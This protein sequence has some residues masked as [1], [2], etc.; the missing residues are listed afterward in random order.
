MK[1]AT[2]CT[3][4][5]IVPV[6]LFVVEAFSQV[7]VSGYVRAMTG[8]PIQGATVTL[9]NLNQTRKTD[10]DG[11]YDFSVTGIQYFADN[12]GYSLVYRGRRLFL[13][14]QRREK[15]SIRFFNLSGKLIRT[16]LD[17]PL[18]AG[19]HSI[20]L[21]ASGYLSQQLYLA[22]IQVG[23]RTV[24][25]KMTVL[26]GNLVGFS[27]A[28]SKSPDCVP[29][30]RSS[31]SAADSMVVTHSNY[32]GGNAYI[33]T[34]KITETTGT[35]NFRM[36]STDTSDTGWWASEMNF[37]FV[38]HHTGVDYYKDKVPDYVTTEQWTQM[39]I[40]Q[41]IWRYPSEIPSDKKWPTYN[42]NI[43][44]DVST[45]VAST[46][47]NTLNF[48]PGYI[49]GKSWWEIVGVQ[50][51]EMVHSYHPFY[52]INGASGFGEAM[53]DAIRCITGFFHWPEGTKC[54]GGYQ[55]SYQGGGRYW[56]FI[57][58]KHPGFIYEIY[59][60][61][62]NTSIVTAVQDITGES[63]DDLCNECESDG[64]PYTLGRGR[65]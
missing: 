50:H 12:A 11:Y 23:S 47:G 4:F 14:L 28:H 45:S 25:Y 41:T 42:C 30:S 35:Q 63:L 24:Y 59:K 37:N 29:L 3:I 26:Q 51:H 52:S 9:V 61:S 13:K 32:F 34:R 8:V 22:K 16:V 15:V 10:A 38:P 17:R 48:N 60:L 2:I 58:L 57:E 40:Q 54:S 18:Q 43:N 31:A 5:F 19:D 56:Y 46:G 64:M 21:G 55:Q 7:T 39:E 36:F 53:C 65:F 49:N 20:E 44:A 1:K 33:N 6:L 62:S 27:E